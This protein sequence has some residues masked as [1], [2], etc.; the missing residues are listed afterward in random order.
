MK[1]APP[2]ISFRSSPTAPRDRDNRLTRRIVWLAA[3]LLFAGVLSG[4]SP[5]TPEKDYFHANVTGPVPGGFK[6]DVPKELG[7]RE[8]AGWGLV[9]VTATPFGADPT[10]LRDS[11]QAIRDAVNF[12]RDRQMVCFFPSGTYRVSDTI[13]CIQN[14]VRGSNGMFWPCVLQGSRRGPRPKIVLSERSPGFGDPTR[15]K[16]VIYF[17][18]RGAGREAPV[19]A[20]QPNILF[21]SM[22][23]NIDVTVEE[24][25]PG[26]VAVRMVGAQGSGVQECTID[27]THGHTG[28]E[29]ASGTGGSHAHVT[30]IGGRIGLDLTESRPGAAVTGITL[31][32]QTETALVYR[33]IEAMCAVGLRIISRSPGPAIVSRASAKN[34]L[35]GQLS[36]VD[37]QIDLQAP[38]ATA[39]ASNSA[40]YLNN[41]YVRGASQIVRNADGSGLSGDPDGWVRVAEYAHGPELPPVKNYNVATPVYLH[42]ER[43]ETDFVRTEPGVVPPDDLQSRHLWSGNFPGFESPGAANVKAA[44]YHAKGDSF[45]D[46]TDAIQRAV[47]EHSIVF[48]PKGYYRI[49]RTIRLRP[50]TQLVGVA[51][52]FSVL[53]TRGSKGDFTDPARPQPLVLTADA[54]E[55]RTL[56]AFCF[57]LVPREMDAAF[58][59]HWQCGPQSV[60]RSAG[61]VLR[62]L[63]GKVPENLRRPPLTLVTGHGGGRWYN[64]YN[65]EMVG[66]DGY[67]HLVL[68]GAAGPLSIYQC[69]IEHVLDEAAQFE[70]RRSQQ[71]SI[72]GMKS[73]GNSPALRAS[74]SSDIRIFGYGGN[75]VP[76]PGSA[77]FVFRRTTGIVLAN[78][79]PR[80]TLPGAGINTFYKRDIGI[81]TPDTWFVLKEETAEGKTVAT[82]PLDFPVL[83]RGTANG[84]DEGGRT[85]E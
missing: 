55:G 3:G 81:G 21:N 60:L 52:T 46:D 65:H 34:V 50:D 58:A 76:K 79:I 24:G 78:I 56:L 68:D 69:N 7:N 12:A 73:E 36:L 26:A 2:D 77:L 41:V 11:T 63:G 72:Y 4:A 64:F 51:Q 33:G 22:F 35:S 31:E 83:Y 74:D 61:S 47:D 48:L 44:P 85:R 10:G 54:R 23:V 15:P 67:R 38:D 62:P 1:Y 30:V 32:G 18:A 49:S 70:I 17:W 6:L 82:R 71:V 20:E 29:G 9:D 14:P 59:L 66:D 40:L 75:L 43:R 39:V 28:L 80:L 16:R 27:V 84:P 53:M 57:I 8:L 45:T 25:N 19:T 42:G 13:E 5:V 37:S